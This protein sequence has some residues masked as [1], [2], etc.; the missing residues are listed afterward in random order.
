MDIFKVNYIFLE[1]NKELV[2]SI[3]SKNS[4]SIHIRRGDYLSSGTIDTHG[5]C[6][7]DY[8]FNALSHLKN[9]GEL[10]DDTCFYIF[11]DDIP[12]CRENLSFGEKMIFMDS[13]QEQ[14]E[15][16]IYLMSK[17]KSNII[18]NSSFSWWGAW[19]NESKNKTVIAP[20]QWF[21]SEVLSSKTIIPC[22]W[23]KI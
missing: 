10:N 19:L 23:I 12:W 8:Y 9:I 17:C 15:M 4:V 21:S 22:D 18:A 3:N 1:E 20:I 5:I 2:N 6:N 11:S 13:F 14:P 16:D 7:K